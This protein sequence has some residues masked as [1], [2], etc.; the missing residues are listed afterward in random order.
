M[1]LSEHESTINSLVVNKRKGKM[2]K[3]NKKGEK[4]AAESIRMKNKNKK[5]EAAEAISSS[6]VVI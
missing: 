2:S 3:E 1:L 5:N 4:K 6:N